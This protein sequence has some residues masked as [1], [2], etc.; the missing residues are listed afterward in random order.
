MEQTAAKRGYLYEDFRLFHLKDASMEPV[1][2]HY[3]SFHKILV[4]LSG[5]AGYAIEGK[6]YALEPGDLVLVP[7]GCIHRPEVSG[8]AAYE[9]I[10]LYI[11]PAF[12]QRAAM[13]CNLEACFSQA[14]QDYSYVLR[15]AGQTNRLVQLLT[16]LEGAMAE[17]G[18]GAALLCQTLL[19]QFLIH[20]TKDTA[21]HQLRYVTM[22]NCD[23]KIVS[24]LKYL[25]LH[26]TQRLSIDSLASQFY[27]S[28]Y[29]MMR[30]FKAETGYTIHAYLNEKRLLLA[31]EQIA[32]GKNPSEIW[33]K[34]GFGDY[35][36]FFRAYKKQFGVSP[37]A[38]ETEGGTSIPAQPI[39]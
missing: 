31:K 12:L 23:E 13:N 29:Y 36:T 2:W 37:N 39:D 34:C 19:L 16:Q 21:S 22:A 9:R 7:K 14:K 11:S 3:H 27:M 1:G 33:E 30:K 5:H 38:K 10:I 26:L 35:S 32:A 8:S 4:F 28:K 15:P 20:L 24:I 17:G 18:F 25:N 6:S